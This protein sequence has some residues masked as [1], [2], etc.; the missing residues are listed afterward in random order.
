MKV[1]LIA[2]ALSFTLFCTAC[3]AAW[4]STLDS[5][6][7]AGAPALIDILQIVAVA[8]GQPFNQTLATKIDTD[9]ANLKQIAASFASDPSGNACQELNE[10]VATYQGDLQLVEQVTQVTN[11]QT[12][13]KILLLT[14]LVAGTIDAITAVIPSCSSTA[15]VKMVNLT[16]PPPNLRNFVTS[17]NSVL[18]A[19][20][21]YA[22]V[23]AKTAHL[24]IHEHSKFWRYTSLGLLK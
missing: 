11:P 21:G 12:Q 10:Y 24:R 1:K 19:K 4:I 23:D 13:Q 6:L 15:N 16:V 22:V 5:I 17:Y 18:V 20:T 9:A 2:V 14:T 3:S 8:N 7:A